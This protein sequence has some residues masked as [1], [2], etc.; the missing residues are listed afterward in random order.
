MNTMQLELY[1]AKQKTKNYFF[2]Q[3]NDS[4]HHVEFSCVI[5]KLSNFYTAAESGLHCLTTFNIGKSNI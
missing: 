5:L 3:I 4:P 2:V 1:I